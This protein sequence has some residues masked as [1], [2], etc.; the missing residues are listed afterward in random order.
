MLADWPEDV[1]GPRAILI[2]TGSE[3]HLAVAAREQLT[4]RGIAARGS[5]CRA[6]NCST[7]PSA[8]QRVSCPMTASPRIAIE[9]GVSMGWE[10]YAATF[11]GINRFGASAPYQTIYK[12]LGLTADNIV[13]QCSYGC[14]RKATAASLMTNWV[15]EPNAFSG[16]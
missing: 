11:I 3:V 9:A 13:A 8:Y 10:R 12:E 6:G 4:A 2:S 1:D 7:Q 15:G 5:A 14:G 16:S